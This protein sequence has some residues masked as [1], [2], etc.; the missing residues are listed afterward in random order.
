MA[1]I[2][3]GRNLEAYRAA[4]RTR[5]TLVEP[6][7]IGVQTVLNMIFADS[8][9]KLVCQLL[10]FLPGCRLKQEQLDV[11]LITL[12]SQKGVRCLMKKRPDVLRLIVQ[13][14]FVRYFRV[15]G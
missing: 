4:A 6:I 14:W 13:A 8:Y 10:G 7:A 3:S 2:L 9:A 15:F 5:G 11:S 1:S 12:V